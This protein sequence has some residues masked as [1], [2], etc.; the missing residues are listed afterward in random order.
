MCSIFGDCMV[1][2]KNDGKPFEILTKEI[3][4]ALV[5][6]P[7]YTKVKHNV[8]L[9]GKDGPRQIDVLI[10]AQVSSLPILTI[11]ECKDE[12]RNLNVQYIDALH[13]KMQ[14]VN[15]SKAVLVA[16]KGFSKKALQKAKR[17]G[18]TLCTVME[19]KSALWN[20]GFQVPVIVT[21][22]VSK[23]FNPRF[24]AFHK[25]GTQIDCKSAVIINDRYLPEYFRDSLISG[26]IQFN[27]V[28][29]G[30]IWYPQN[31]DSSNYIRDVKGN[32]IDIEQLEI[33]VELEI[34]YYFGYLN[35]L[36]N[37]RAL[38]NKTE[39]TMHIMFKTEEIFDYRNNFAP[40]DK[41]T[42]PKVDGIHIGCV[43]IP[44]VE[45]DG[46]DMSIVRE[47]TGDSWQIKSDKIGDT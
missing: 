23:N 40:F 18:I 25:G 3:F 6:N 24:R 27:D 20:I 10:Q 38:L 22:I 47:E 26:V 31:L 37:T 4:E 46:I 35:D 43:A 5:E 1:K 44:E 12:S 11:I 8:K 16:R 34:T 14:D 28:E 33:Y 42:L 39:D 17:L 7:A 13:S 2:Q 15:A 21:H 30:Q 19:A 32:R 45:I 41:A 9:D 36:E 29:K